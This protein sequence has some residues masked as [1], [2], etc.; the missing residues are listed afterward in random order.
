[1]RVS[2]VGAR[3]AKSLATISNARLVVRL[4]AISVL[5]APISVLAAAG[6]AQKQQQHRHVIVT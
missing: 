2:A 5:A 6:A 3:F 1:M 4:C